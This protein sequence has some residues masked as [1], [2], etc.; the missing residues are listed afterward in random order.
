MLLGFVEPKFVSCTSLESEMRKVCFLLLPM[1]LGS[2]ASVGE[3][4][5]KQ[6]YAALDSSKP[7]SL[8]AE[9]IRDTWQNTKFGGTA[10]AAQLQ[11]SGESYLVLAPAGATPVEVAKISSGT[12]SLHFAGGIFEWRKQKRLESVK[13]C[14]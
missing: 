7:A 6:P 8:L 1:L 4:S 2:C 10:V 3:I 13:A 5:Q 12:V 11:K 14:L 9:C